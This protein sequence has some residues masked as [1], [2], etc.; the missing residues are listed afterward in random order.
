MPKHSLIDSSLT[1]LLSSHCCL[2]SHRSWISD[3]KST[4]NDSMLKGDESE[5]GYVKR[6]ADGSHQ[7]AGVPEVVEK[8]AKIYR[9]WE[10]PQPGAALLPAAQQLD[11]MKE[12]KKGEPASAQTAPAAAN[13]DVNRGAEAA[14]AAAA[15]AC[16]ATVVVDKGGS[17]VLSRRR[18]SQQQS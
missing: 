13:D 1:P 17:H 4:N 9:A 14:A 2:P 7:L 10:N 16:G 3:L 11:P 6:L 5:G 12:E 15:A 18:R 8:Y